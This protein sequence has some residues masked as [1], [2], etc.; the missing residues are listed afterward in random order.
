[1]KD[2]LLKGSE[3]WA[4]AY[5]SY[6]GLTVHLNVWFDNLNILLI[7]VLYFGSIKILFSQLKKKKLNNPHDGYNKQIQSKILLRIRIKIYRN[8]TIFKRYMNYY[9]ISYDILCPIPWRTRFISK[10]THFNE[11]SRMWGFS[12]FYF[13]L[14]SKLFLTYLINVIGNIYI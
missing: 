8:F 4:W 1:M 13:P 5:W 10:P 7:M 12:M 11:T 2:V 14:I 3:D 6:V 9:F